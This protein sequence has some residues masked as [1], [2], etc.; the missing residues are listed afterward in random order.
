M[1]TTSPSHHIPSP[2]RRLRTWAGER[3]LAAHRRGELDRALAGEHGP[4]V[5]ADFLAA[6]ERAA[7]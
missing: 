3:R 6:Q 4:G 2:V 7:A 1:S 5:R